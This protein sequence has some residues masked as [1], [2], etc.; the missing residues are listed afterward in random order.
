MVMKIRVFPPMP[1]RPC[2]FCLSLQGDSVFADFAADGAG[3]VYL[4]RIS[5]D[6]YGCCEPSGLAQSGVMSGPDSKALRDAVHRGEVETPSVVAIL[7]AYFS[8]HQDLLWPDAL[9]DHGL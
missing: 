4:V 6:G 1:A 7:T 3:R 9:S 5:Y 8:R 2:D